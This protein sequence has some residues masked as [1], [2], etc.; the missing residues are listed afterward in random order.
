MSEELERLLL[1]IGEP[2]RFVS[3]II[4]KIIIMIIFK[5]ISKIIITRIIMII[6]KII[7]DVIV[8]LIMMTS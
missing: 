8:M 1:T 4:F 7:N 2:A 5:I 6:F 3:K